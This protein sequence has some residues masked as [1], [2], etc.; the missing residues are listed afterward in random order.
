MEHRAIPII[1]HLPDHGAD[2]LAYEDG[3]GWWL[4]SYFPAEDGCD[5][6]D[7]VAGWRDNTGDAH[8]PVTHWM[9]SGAIAPLGRPARR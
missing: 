8:G 9:R 2:V 3:V 4:A 1:E 6:N 7:G 5:P